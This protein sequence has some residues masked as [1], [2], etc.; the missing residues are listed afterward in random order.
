MKRIF[1]AVDISDE[2]RRAAAAHTEHIRQRIRNVRVSWIRP[3]SMHVTMKFLGDVDERR[4]EAVKRAVS[5]SVEG[6]GRFQA[7]LSTPEA[8]GNYLR[9]ETEKWARVVKAAGIQPQ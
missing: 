4:L 5:K 9:S 7:T 8:F 1:I 3:E 6:I 2:A